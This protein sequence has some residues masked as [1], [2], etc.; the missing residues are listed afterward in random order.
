MAPSVG[1]HAAE[2][3]DDDDDRD[4]LRLRFSVGSAVS[5]GAAAAGAGDV[6]ACRRARLTN[7]N[8]FM[9]VRSS[10]SSP[11]FLLYC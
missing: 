2:D 8:S 6:G 3:P 9:C 10:S 4:G 1:F 5:S 7:A 11:G